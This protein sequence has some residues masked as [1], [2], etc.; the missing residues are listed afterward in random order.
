MKTVFGQTIT[1]HIT[2][3]RLALYGGLDVVNAFRNL[4]ILKEYLLLLVGP[5]R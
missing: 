3:C 4:K 2:L 5:D 1:C